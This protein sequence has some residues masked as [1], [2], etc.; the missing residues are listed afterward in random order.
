MLKRKFLVGQR[1]DPTIIIHA[2]E[3]R[4][5]EYKSLTPE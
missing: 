4:E 2:E 3:R 1:K 5:F